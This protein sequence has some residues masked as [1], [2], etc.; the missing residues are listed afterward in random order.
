MTL[1]WICIFHFESGCYVCWLGCI[2]KTIKNSKHVRCTIQ[3][4]LII[5]LNSLSVVRGA[6]LCCIFQSLTSLRTLF[7]V[8]LIVKIYFPYL[9]NNYI[10]KTNSQKLA[11][12]VT[13]ILLQFINVVGNYVFSIINKQKIIFFLFH[14][15]VLTFK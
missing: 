13:F 11:C 9:E 6:Y 12:C 10:F 1:N 15:E 2:R 8:I 3:Q 7:F 5:M 4:W 14:L